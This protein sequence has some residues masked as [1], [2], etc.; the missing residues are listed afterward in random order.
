MKFLRRLWAGEAGFIVS[1]EL[2][3][4]ATILV[5]GA[6]LADSCLCGTR[7]YWSWWIWDK[8]S[9]LWDRT[10]RSKRPTP[11]RSRCKSGRAGTQPV[12]PPGG[13]EL[14]WQTNVCAPATARRWCRY[15]TTR[16]S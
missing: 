16:S 15:S 14:G 11:A 1:A 10:T 12:A 8:Q 13:G 4:V 5:L 6:I 9:P 7:S 2:V 3:L